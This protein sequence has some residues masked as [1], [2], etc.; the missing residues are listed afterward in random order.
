[1]S[2]ATC[3]ELTRAALKVADAPLN[4]VFMDTI[5]VLIERIPL[6]AGH[7]SRAFVPI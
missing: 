7:S 3:H 2:A 5:I 6:L 1:M 4:C